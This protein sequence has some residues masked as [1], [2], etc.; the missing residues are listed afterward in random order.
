MKEHWLGQNVPKLGFGMMRLPAA[1]DGTI[2]LPQICDM[3]DAYLAAGFTYFDT[4]Y[5]YMDGKSEETVGKALVQRHPRE[6]YLLA[7]KLPLWE[8]NEKS[9]MQ[10]IVDLQLARTGAQYFDFYL[11]HALGASRLEK[12][13]ELGTWAF[14]K[15]LKE[16]G[17]AKHIGFSFH[18]NAQ[19]LDDI[20]TAHPEVEFVQL[21][22]NYV[23]WDDKGV[24]SR[25]CYEV[26]MKHG[27]SVIIMEPV[28]GGALAT[29]NDGARA[30]MKAARP[31]HT[32]AAWALRYCA[33]LDKVVTVLSG[34]SDMAQ[35]RDNI[36][37]MSSFEKM[38]D[39][40][41][42]VIEQ[43]KEIMAGIPTIP[44][45]DCRYCMEHCPQNIPIPRILDAENK[46][47]V[48]GVTNKGHYAFITRGKGKA[49]DCIQCG[50]CEG[51]CPQHIG[52]I[53][54]L[55]QCAETF[56]N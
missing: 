21:Q 20:L 41:Q 31:D 35:M 29:L 28:K 18:D 13:D 32:P 49:S 43:V 25:L 39:A 54:L 46:R 40:D 11:L 53:P 51:R 47:R 36:G 44:C 37:T 42:A 33:S 17:I 45:T 12:L 15:S 19:V 52:I 7:T 30:A 55:E 4:A 10:R 3:V 27:V 14:L 26:A 38:T 24:Q 56:E 50:V 1:Q 16:R 6:S 48:Y 9:D 22:I 34:M 8:L 5:G 2:D 23:D